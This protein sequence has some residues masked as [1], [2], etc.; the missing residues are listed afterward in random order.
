M[1]VHLGGVVVE[2][3]AQFHIGDILQPQHIA[4]GQ[5]LDDQFA[6]LFSRGEATAILH[7]VLVCRGMVGTERA[8]GRLDVLL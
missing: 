7:R 4:T 3:I 5:G 2:F 8:G 1:S 6:E